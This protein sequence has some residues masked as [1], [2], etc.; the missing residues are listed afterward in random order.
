MIRLRHDPMRLSKQEKTHRFRCSSIVFLVFGIDLMAS[1]PNGPVSFIK[2]IALGLIFISGFYTIFSINR[3]V[4]TSAIFKLIYLYLFLLTV[5]LFYDFVLLQTPF[6]MYHNISSLFIIFS[7]T[8]VLPAVIFGTQRFTIDFDKLILCL[9]ILSIT[10]LLLSVRD[11]F[12][13]KMIAL[14]GGR[15]E[16][17]GVLDTIYLGHQGTTLILLTL[18]KFKNRLWFNI[19]C[20]IVG[21]LS[22]SCSGSRGPTLALLICISIYSLFNVQSNRI[23]ALVILIAIV[24]AFTYKDIISFGVSYFDS[25]GIR[26]FD[27]IAAFLI[28]QDINGGRENIYESGIEYF[29]ENPILGKSYLLP[30]LSYVHNIFIEQFMALGFVGGA[31]F[32]F[33]ML[34]TLIVGFKNWRD[35]GLKNVSVF[36]II[37]IQ[38]I[39]F[40]CFSRTII[41][42]PQLWICTFL[43][44]HYDEFRYIRQVSE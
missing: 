20:L 41:A 15:F 19:P 10:I 44:L 2:S 5:R 25:I 40:G 1:F 28:G 23:R 8:I 12:T 42:L 30:D 24:I 38:Y 37:F 18:H 22:L 26:S 21:L 3:K 16:G 32:F 35:K 29:F 27:R 39:I 17:H 31:I 4:C 7:G 36:F 13:G 34:Y 9:K 6:F 33:I 14:N 11:I 43:I